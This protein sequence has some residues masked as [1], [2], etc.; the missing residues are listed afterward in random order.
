MW[1]KKN[2]ETKIKETKSKY[3]GEKDYYSNTEYV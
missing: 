2:H 1:E 3:S